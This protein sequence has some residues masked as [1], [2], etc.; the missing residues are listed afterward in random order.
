[1]TIETG[2]R[3]AI[4]ICDLDALSRR[5]PM[6]APMLLSQF[7]GTSSTTVLVNE[8]LDSGAVQL[9]RYPA[10]YDNDRL[11]ALVDL[12]QTSIGPRHIG[13]RI[14]CYYQNTRG[15]WTEIRPGNWREK[16]QRAAIA[17]YKQESAP[18]QIA[19]RL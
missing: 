19:M 12:L 14:R 13:R 2:M 3:I 15:N 7:C 5:V 6:L 16:A 1:M 9:D 18:R 11:A 8:N 10:A 4:N 17:L